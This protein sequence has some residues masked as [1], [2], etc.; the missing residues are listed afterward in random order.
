MSQSSSVGIPE[1]VMMIEEA[2]IEVFVSTPAALDLVSVCEGDWQLVTLDLHEVKR[3]SLSSG[4]SLDSDTIKKPPCKYFFK[5]VNTKDL[6]L[7]C[8]L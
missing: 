6:V 5:P 8:L 7:K 1:K 2:R 4:T 3:S